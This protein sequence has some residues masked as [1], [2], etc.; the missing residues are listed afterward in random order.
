MW[1]WTILKVRLSESFKAQAWPMKSISSFS[2][3]S[4]DLIKGFAR[5]SIMRP[6][7]PSPSIVLFSQI[8]ELVPNWFDVRRFPSPYDH[9]ISLASGKP[10]RGASK[11]N[12]GLLETGSRVVYKSRQISCHQIWH[13]KSPI[14]EDALRNR[15][16]RAL[17]LINSFLCQT[18]RLLFRVAQVVHKTLQFYRPR[19][20]KFSTL[21]DNSVF[22]AMTTR[23]VL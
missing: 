10:L 12:G 2:S 21:G 16:R 13:Y 1:F 5:S 7:N 20:A 11:R 3:T 22:R 19:L 14:S 9:I 6:S 23:Q 18:L 15:L 4:L 8:I 17:T